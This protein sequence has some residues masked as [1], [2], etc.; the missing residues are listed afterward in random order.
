[1]DWET[2][3]K[4]LILAHLGFTQWHVENTL[5][6]VEAALKLGCDGVEV[7]LRMTKDGELVVFHDDDL[8]RLAGRDDELEEM[9][10]STLREVRIGQSRIPMLEELLDLVQDKALLN[11]EIKT[12]RPFSSKVEKKLLETLRSFRLGPTILVSSFHPL[13]L[14]RR[15]KLSPELRRGYLF[16]Q[17]YRRSRYRALTERVIDPFSLNPAA[18]SVTAERSEESV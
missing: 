14:R 1:M 12:V 2:S 18:D 11:L 10:V 16:W 7:D 3:K 4:P 9:T 17:K 5:E 15:R 6:A 8:K 13:P